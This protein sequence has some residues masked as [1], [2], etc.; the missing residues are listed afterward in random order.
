MGA[1]GDLKETDRDGGG[2]GGGGHVEAAGE[3]CPGEDGEVGV[4]AVEQLVV[5]FQQAN[6]KDQNLDD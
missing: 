6:V 2:V 1:G 5:C 4:E 3:D